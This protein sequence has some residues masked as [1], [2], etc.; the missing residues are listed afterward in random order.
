MLREFLTWQALVMF[1]LGVMLSAM[2]KS[3]AASAR[4]KVAGG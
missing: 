3:F 2:V 4:S 1:V